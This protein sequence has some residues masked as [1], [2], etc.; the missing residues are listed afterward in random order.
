MT[1]DNRNMGF[2]QWVLLCVLF[3]VSGVIIYFALEIDR[4]LR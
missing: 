1:R 4:K 2:L 3:S